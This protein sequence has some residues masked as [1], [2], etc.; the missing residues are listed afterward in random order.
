[1]ERFHVTGGQPWPGPGRLLLRKTRPARTDRRPATALSQFGRTF[2]GEEIIPA[3]MVA[4]RPRRPGP[5]CAPPRR[6]PHHGPSCHSCDVLKHSETFSAMF[7]VDRFGWSPVCDHRS[8]SRAGEPSRRAKEG[9]SGRCAAQGSLQRRELCHRLIRRSTSK[10][11]IATGAPVS[12]MTD[13]Q[14][15]PLATGSTG[16]SPVRSPSRSMDSKGQ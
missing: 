13:A 15:H 7:Q 14:D 6:V 9:Q 8:R 3:G 12:T 1:M 10:V 5:G 2:N 11:P 4:G 16:P